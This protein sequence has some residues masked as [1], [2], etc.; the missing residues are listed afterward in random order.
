MKKILSLIFSDGLNGVALGIFCTYAIGTILQQIGTILSHDIGDLFITV[1]GIAVMLTGAGIAMGIL[2]KVKAASTVTLACII[3]G[4]VGAH[5]DAIFASSVITGEGSVKF[6]GPGDPLGACI[7]IMVTLAVGSLVAGKT[8]FDLLLTPVVCTGSGIISG[9]FFAPVSDYLTNLLANALTWGKTQNEIVMGIVVSCLMCIYTM[10][11]VSTL[12]IIHLASLTGVSAG[13]ATIGCCCS[14]IGFAVASYRDN[15]I[16]GLFIQ[17]IGTSKLQLANTIKKPY[18][19]LPAL[20]SSGILGGVSSAVFKLTNNAKGASYGTTGL[21]GCLKAYDHMKDAM[22]T[23]ESLIVVSLLCF[24]LPG[25]LS[26]GFAELLRKAKL[27]KDGD[28]KIT[29]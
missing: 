10:L 6:S 14:M 4:M 3:A 5:A 11:P 9:L 19:L 26:L 24:V 1:G 21:Q 18:I 12:S 25:V 28:M 13:C 17:G 8:E 27:L 15:K 29:L 20:V 2:S 16:C 7:A 23:T 22:G